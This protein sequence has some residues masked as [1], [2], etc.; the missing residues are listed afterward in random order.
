MKV[1]IDREECTS[2][3]LCWDECPEVFE[4]SDDDGW[5]Q[6]VEEFRKNN[7]ASSGEVGGDLEECLQG[8]ADGCPVE[9][10]HVGK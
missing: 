8:A 7:D 4:E 10:I 6:I 3:G 2:C 1:T 5:S 9:I